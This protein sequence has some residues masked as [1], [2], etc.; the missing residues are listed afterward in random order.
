MRD[1]QIKINLDYL[2]E[3]IRAIRTHIGKDV[4]LGL[5][6]KGNAYGHGAPFMAKKLQEFGV[7]RFLVATLMEALQLRLENKAY[8]L[9]VMGHT[10]DAYL[11]LMVAHKIMPT[12]FTMKQAEIL[13][14][15]GKARNQVIK[16]HLKLDTGFNRL[17]FQI[18]DG[19]IDDLL[20]IHA[21]THLEI[22]GIFSHL[23]LKD[24]AGDQNQFKKFMDVTQALSKHGL[25]IPVQHICD[26]IA[27]NLYPE[28]HLSMVRI[29]ALAYGLQAEEKPFPG[30][31]QILTMDTL[32]SQV[33]RVKK[34]EH[35]SYGN[36]YILSEDANI[37]TL[38]FGYADGYP[39]SLYQ[40]GKVRI[41][42]HYYNYAGIICMDQCMINA[43]N[44][45]IDLNNRVHIIDHDQL[46]IAKLSKLAQTNKNEFLCRLNPRIPR[47]YIQEGKTVCIANELLGEINEF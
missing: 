17:G 40:G 9:M 33:K 35:V 31:K 24:R 42:Q 38:P 22:E 37:V 25:D 39:R 19:L 10:P 5:V 2:E 45:P 3:N 15:I 28:M 14:S 34:G 43:N 36:R 4:I 21:M 13:N 11:D 23:A 32:P 41:G 47:H 26:S 44:D 20:K 1:T 6:L 12:L 18:Q 30:V 27:T 29:G 7:Q 46:S 16:V 8:H